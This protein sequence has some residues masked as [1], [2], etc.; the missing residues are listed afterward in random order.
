MEFRAMNFIGNVFIAI[1]IF[2]RGVSSFARERRNIDFR[3]DISK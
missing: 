3:L 1:L 2:Q